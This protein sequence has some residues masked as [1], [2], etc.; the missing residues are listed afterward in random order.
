MGEYT[1]PE[2]R[3]TFWNVVGSN[4]ALRAPGAKLVDLTSPPY[5]YSSAWYQQPKGIGDTEI[6]L[7]VILKE[8]IEFDD[9]NN[10][11]LYD[12]VYDG[13]TIQVIATECLSWSLPKKKL[14]FNKTVAF[15]GETQSWSTST[16]AFKREGA[17]FE[18]C[19][20]KTMPENIPA[21][22][23]SF[24]IET[25]NLPVVPE[26]PSNTYD[27]NPTNPM[28]V[29][30]NGMRIKINV[31]DFPFRNTNT[32]GKTPV[33]S[34]LAFRFYI[35]CDDYNSQFALFDQRRLANRK[36][37]SNLDN[38]YFEWQPNA[39]VKFPGS[40]AMFSGQFKE[41]P[42]KPSRRM[43]KDASKFYLFFTFYIYIYIVQFLL[44]VCVC[45]V[46]AMVVVQELIFVD[47]SCI[48]CCN[49][50]KIFI[51]TDNFK[52]TTRDIYF[53]LFFP[54]PLGFVNSFCVYYSILIPHVISKKNLQQMT[55][56]YNIYFY[57]STW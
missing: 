19:Q 12:S 48:I 57:R 42:L 33:K 20:R 35:T 53:I 49:N 43:S 3:D 5:V 45:F 37:P 9:K 56:I 52:L 2:T 28:I 39:R 18:K 50:K 44:F 36:K 30:Q 55:S 16:K 11:G 40:D 8:I 10:N 24:E 46:R 25:S 32:T 22:M 27:Q 51:F 38:G 47:Y 29:T 17:A 6:N 15:S 4:S 31:K 26:N 41:Q 13:E 21:N 34:R 14:S 54:F 7:I 23:L 1:A